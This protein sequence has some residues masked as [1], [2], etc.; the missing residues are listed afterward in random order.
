MTS[1]PR[2]ALT[3][4]LAAAA[5]VATL[6]PAAAA[7]KAKPRPPAP[8]TI[9]PGTTSCPQGQGS[10]TYALDTVPGD[11]STDC[12]GFVVG[13]AGGKPEG[14]RADEDYVGTSRTKVKLAKSG[15]ITGSVGVKATTFEGAVPFAGYADVTLTMTINGVEVGSIEKS[16]PITPTADLAIPFSWTIPAAL[17]GKKINAM[18]MY[19]HW[20]VAGGFPFLDADKSSLKLPRS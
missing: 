15:A 7:T 2:R 13:V 6:V 3:L 10:A 17:R 11:A 18:D 4:G 12:L 19:L 14:P 9:Y 1:R 16:G 5:T 8:L 20:N